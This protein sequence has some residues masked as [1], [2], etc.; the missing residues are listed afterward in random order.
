MPE[1]SQIRLLPD[2]PGPERRK[3]MEQLADALSDCALFIPGYDPE[4]RAL[5]AGCGSLLVAAPPA[6]TLERVSKPYLDVSECLPLHRPL[7]LYPI[8]RADR[9]RVLAFCREC[10]WGLWAKSLWYGA[11]RVMDEESLWSATAQL[12]TT[13]GPRSVWLQ[14]DVTGIAETLAFCA[15]DGELLQAAHLTKTQVTPEGKT[16][17]G[18]VAALDPE[19]EHG[20]RGT[21][22]ELRWSGGG[23]LELVRDRGG[24]LSL[25]EVNTRFPSWMWA[26]T[27]AGFNL[28]AALESRECSIWSPWMRGSPAGPSA[29]SDSRAW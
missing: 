27:M 16:W 12:E 28:P 25:L 29:D 4:A 1:F 22:R 3:R 8:D 5:S 24:E 19:T 9:T 14:H 6:A 20:L 26:A 15:L 21:V 2:A 23:E 13:W 11:A 10:D 18:S 7:S 17:V